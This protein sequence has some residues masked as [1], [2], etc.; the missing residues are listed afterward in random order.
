MKKLRLWRFV[1]WLA[2]PVVAVWI[3]RR[4]SGVSIGATLASFQINIFHLLALV[5]FNVAAML[6][7]N[8]RWWLILRSLGYRVPYLSTLRYRLAAFAI[9]YFT[10][11]MQ[12]GGEPVQ[13]YAL[14]ARHA[15]PGPQALASVTL[16][17]LFELLSNFT[18]LAVGLTLIL[19][20]PRKLGLVG[21]RLALW[22]A[23][24]A[25]LPLA[26]L[27]V[28][29]AGHSPLRVLA[30]RL[31][32]RLSM[33]MKERPGVQMAL[34]AACGAEEQMG[35]LIRRKP[36]LILQIMAS[37]ALIWTLSL[38]EYW[39]ALRVLGVSLTLAQTVLA[40][41]AARLAFLTPLPGG[42][43]ALEAG[44]ILAMS[45]LG[46]SPLTGVAISMWIRARD[47]ALGAVGAACGTALMEPDL[48]RPFSSTVGD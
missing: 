24:L 10:P 22:S 40:L 32:P 19:D 31:E 25:L 26:Y 3:W 12:F 6:F 13:V 4:A 9:S 30:G 42:L 23:G 5:L 46:L 48:V 38:I 45:L 1:F 47:I 29:R 8:S 20:Y 39:L 36:G 35:D 7:F 41:T 28:V 27:F 18:F 44:Q 14:H 2:F 16:D 21:S 11:G 17:K 15:V 33:R 37:S 34:G 43:G